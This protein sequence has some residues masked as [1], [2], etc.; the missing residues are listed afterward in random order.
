VVRSDP[1]FD[2]TTRLVFETA[3]RLLNQRRPEQPLPTAA[4]I[5]ADLR[6][7]LAAVAKA[8]QDLSDDYL[9]MKVRRD[10]QYAEMLGVK[11]EYPQADEPSRSEP[12]GGS[13]PNSRSG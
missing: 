12:R 10:W 5:A 2:P 11:R 7:Q 9:Y 3:K 13:Q 1:E 8:L 4:D 6:M